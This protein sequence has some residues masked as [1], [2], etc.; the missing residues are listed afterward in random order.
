MLSSTMV[1][2]KKVLVL[3][4]IYLSALLGLSPT[5]TNGQASVDP[6]ENENPQPSVIRRLE[7]ADFFNTLDEYDSSLVLFYAPWCPKSKKMYPGFVEAA[8]SLRTS[9]PG[10]MFAKVNSV[11]EKMLAQAMDVKGYPSV[12][13]FSPGK[14]YKAEFKGA[15]TTRATDFR[16]FVI[17][18]SDGGA[19]A[20]L[21]K[22]VEQAPSDS[23]Q[24]GG[25][26]SNDI[27]DSD[28]TSTGRQINEDQE[29]KPDPP[30]ASSQ[31]SGPSTSSKSDNVPEDVDASLPPVLSFP[32]LQLQQIIKREISIPGSGRQILLIYSAE[33]PLERALTLGFE[34][35]ARRHRGKNVVFIAVDSADTRA[36][37]R[38]K[39]SRAGL[40]V[41]VG[42][43]YLS[44][45]TGSEER[46]I[47]YNDKAARARQSLKNL[48]QK[49]P[50]D[51]RDLWR[52]KKL[53]ALGELIWE[54]TWMTEI[55]LFVNGKLE[56]NPDYI[57][58]PVP[59]WTALKS[60]PVDGAYSASS[61]VNIVDVN[62]DSF[63]SE[64]IDVSTD[65]MVLVH[66]PWCS[67]C[68]SFKPTFER[69]ARALRSSVSTLKVCR[70][71]GDKNDVHGL[72]VTSFPTLFIFPALEKEAS[73]I[74]E[75][76]ASDGWSA[77]S[78]LAWAAKSTTFA[79]DNKAVSRMAASLIASEES[80]S[81]DA[82]SND[83]S[84]ADKVEL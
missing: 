44:S 26:I 27:M 75:F 50:E 59:Q 53:T 24:K 84:Q 31:S 65:V 47:M 37:R 30:E 40:P 46:Y 21:D 61:E 70:M 35:V 20:G 77:E 38:L 41:I 19:S 79:F 34:R 60:S 56:R 15:A 28:P 48:L 81:A 57:A 32:S 8:K 45:E 54:R 74:E 52:K 1:I 33:D 76:S 78:V 23:A 36:L 17:R 4:L 12:F 69:V 82:S 62:A 7:F 29:A 6:T 9:H 67:H 68:K 39:L 3:L 55:D 63:K 64:V 5:Q 18:Q 25:A 58:P 13:W 83:T 10:V 66:A 72:K 51:E 42:I 11:E 73:G 22:K 16:N 71:D 49:V 43:D 14:T 80:R 2:V